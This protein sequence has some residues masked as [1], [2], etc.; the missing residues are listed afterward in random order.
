MKRVVRLLATVAMTSLATTAIGVSN[1]DAKECKK[2]T[3]TIE[4]DPFI[5]RQLGAFPHSLFVWRRTIRE[6]YGNGWQPWRKAEDRKIDCQQSNIAGLG[7]RWICTRTARPCKGVGAEEGATGGS[8]N[9][10][11]VITGTLRRGDEGAQVRALQRLLQDN[12]QDVTVDGKYGR[13][14]EAAVRRFQR[15]SGLTADGVAGPKT[16]AALGGSISSSSSSG[17]S[18][19]ATAS[20]ITQTLRRG[21]SGAQVRALQ[22]ILVG[23]GYSVKV[24]GKFGR[25]TERAV[26]DFQRKEGLTADGVVG[27]QTRGRMT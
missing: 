26:K 18:S 22:E 14:T 1:A 19:T 5:S 7:K 4:S 16:I 20:T 15:D 21:D 17:N 27:A 2:E 25:G 24:D 6:K 11:N 13:G 23:A 10:G 9:P 12:G 8:T 3:T